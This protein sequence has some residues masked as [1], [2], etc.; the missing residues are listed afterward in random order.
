MLFRAVSDRRALA[1]SH[2]PL[3]LLFQGSKQLKE[4]ESTA[5]SLGGRNFA[6]DEAQ[7][8][9]TIAE[10]ENSDGASTEVLPLTQEN[11]NQF[12]NNTKQNGHPPFNKTAGVR[13]NGHGPPS[14][15]QTQSNKT[16]TLSRP[17]SDKTGLTNGTARTTPPLPAITPR[18]S[19]SYG[20][21]T[22]STLTPRGNK[23]FEYRNTK[24]KGFVN[25]R[26]LGIIPD[27]KG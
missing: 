16:G 7:E 2:A 9:E 25:L 1:L 13:P 4:V 8:L 19:N 14:T 20:S 23:I 15:A 27:W 24:K 11:L 5:V 26:K 22:P 10:S 18:G 3:C 21:T 17:L 12:D 6:P